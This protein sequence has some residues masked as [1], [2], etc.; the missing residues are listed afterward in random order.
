MVK[1]APPD[2][3]FGGWVDARIRDMIKIDKE[4]AERY[5]IDAN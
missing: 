5:K 2:S 1:A 3:S 4:R